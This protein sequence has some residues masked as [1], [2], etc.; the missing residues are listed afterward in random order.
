MMLCVYQ[1]LVVVVRGLMLRPCLP[2]GGMEDTA[3]RTRLA[4]ISRCWLNQ[5]LPHSN[6]LIP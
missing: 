4:A 3:H 6:L 5:E 2:T 1:S